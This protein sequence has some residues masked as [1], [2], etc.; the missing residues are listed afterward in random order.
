MES[1][2][3]N[4]IQKGL[5]ELKALL[6]TKPVDEPKMVS[7][8]LADGG[9]VDVDGEEGD[10][11][12]KNA[13]VGGEPAPDGEHTLADGRVLVV[14]AGVVTEVKEAA[15]EESAADKLKAQI[16]ELQAQLKTAEAEKS[17]I[18][19]SKV[20]ETTKAAEMVAKIEKELKEIKAATVGKTEK[21]IKIKE[22]M[23]TPIGFK[24]SEPNA[25]ALDLTKAFINEN[26][27]YLKNHY[28]PG[29]FDNTPTMTSIL[30]T[31]FNYTYPGILTTDIFYK[32]TLQSPAL[33]DIFTID[34]D[35]K[36][37]KVYNLVTQ[38]DKIVRPYTGCGADV[39]TNRQLITNTEVQT[40]EFQMYEGWCK[41]DFTSQLTGV[42]NNLAQEWLKTGEAQFDPA[43][44]PIDK[45]IMTVLKDGMQRDIF[46]RVS[47][48]AGDSADADYNQFDGLWTRNIDS[49]GAANYCVRRAGTALG[50][51]ALSAGNALTHLDTMWNASSILLRNQPNKKIFVT[52]SIWENYAASMRGVGSVTEQAFANQQSGTPT[53]RYNGVDVIPVDLWD[54]FLAESDNPL[55]ASAR[56]LIMMTVRE[57]HI[58]GVENGADLN[59]I[60]S[61]FEKKDQKRY[62]RSS[63]KLGYNYLHCDLSTIMY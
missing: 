11:V 34:Q 12:G 28:E 62:Y 22:A 42:Y 9:T 27:Q 55:T 60:D 24:R 50:T 61:W 51:G 52:R 2:E 15:P 46:R 32:P 20:A 26:M 57:N 14:A 36:F 25:V 23:N 40:K 17:A 1:S 31:S 13:M 37:K 49:S 48:A 18:E 58:L 53:L 7:L 45:V 33:S 59:S 63:F 54:V 8:E 44:T 43:G 38:L 30:E 29:Y 47:F 6:T 16:E 3:R 41:D 10:L 5:D 19:V 35:I 4:L 56:H 39:N 21:P